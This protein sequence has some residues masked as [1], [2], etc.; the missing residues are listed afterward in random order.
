MAARSRTT[1]LL[2]FDGVEASTT[3]TS[4]IETNGNNTNDTV[5]LKNS[6]LNVP[7]GFG[8]YFPSSGKLT[9]DNSTINAKTMGVQVCSGSLSIKRVARLPLRAIRL[10]RPRR[11]R[12][13]GRAA[14]SIV[15]RPGYKGLDKVAIT[16]GTFTAKGDN[17]VIKLTPGIPRPRRSR[18]S[19]VPITRS[20]FPTVNLTQSQSWQYR[21]KRR[22]VH[23]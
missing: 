18:I 10:Q 11:W 3:A 19:M 9:I 17:A 4:G 12:Y 22:Q 13:P 23:R 5:V 6:T 21:S 15:N 2:T 7:N 16:G 1:T 14:I 8:I 20:P